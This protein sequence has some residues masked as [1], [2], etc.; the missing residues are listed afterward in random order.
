MNEF[1]LFSIELEGGVYP[2][3]IYFSSALLY[4]FD[5]VGTK[6]FDYITFRFKIWDIYD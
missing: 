3:D 4:N 6:S 2:K 5:V 1:I